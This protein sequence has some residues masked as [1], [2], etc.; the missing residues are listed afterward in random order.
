MIRFLIRL[1]IYIAAA[2]IALTIAAVLLSGFTINARSFI[3]VVVLFA[4]MQALLTPAF[5]QAANNKAPV[6][7]GGVG[8][9][10][11]FVSL[12]VTAL[13][14]DGLSIDGIWTWILATFLI[15]IVGMLAMFILPLI[16]IKN[17]VE[18]RRE[19]K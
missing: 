12:L 15:W 9:G 2:A 11:A 1:A 19:S 3:G 18:D 6:L 4:L 7:Q 14:T 8:L 17:R 13:F 10:V 5:S 16:F